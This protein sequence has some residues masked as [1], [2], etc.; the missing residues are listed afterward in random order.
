MIPVLIGVIAALVLV[1][2]LAVAAFVFRTPARDT[3]Q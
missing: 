1:T 3:I 2:C